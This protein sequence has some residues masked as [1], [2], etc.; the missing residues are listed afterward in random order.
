MSGGGGGGKGWIYALV[1]G[2]ILCGLGQAHVGPGW[3]H[4][5]FLAVGGLAVVFASCEAMILSVEALGKRLRWNQFVAGTVAGLASNV[6]EVVMLAFVILKE[7]RVAFVVTALTL[8]VG[9]LVFGIYS[10]LLPRDE[11]GQAR[12]PDPLVKLSTDLYACAGGAFLAVGSVMILMRLFNR[13]ENDAALTS[14]DLYAIGS[15]LLFVEVVAVWYLV[16]RFSAAEAPQPAAV[17]AAADA[18]AA[19]IAEAPAA[20]A[21]T[22]EAPAAEAP[23]KPAPAEAEH[24]EE[25]PGWGVVLFFGALGVATSILGGHAVGEFAD[26]L[27]SA[28]TL[29]GYS[30]MVCAIVIAVFASAGAFLMLASAHSKGMHDLA[31]ANISGQVN[32]VPFVVMPISMILIGLFVQTGV[33]KD[34]KLLP[35]GGGALAIDLETTSVMFLSF[36]IMLILWKSVQDDG[37]VNW[38]E[39]ASMVALFGLTVYLLAQHG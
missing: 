38:L 30:E 29:R 3:L 23:A 19:Q 7:P 14:G 1:G 10:G 11:T 26:A 9:A 35:K 31:L 36:P 18:P 5:A 39:T 16:R 32:Q 34:P 25:M 12:M 20:E 37:K 21:P 15:C 2:A 24:E 4:A 33:I 22:A 6:P 8:H 17:A 27:V 28:L 13:G